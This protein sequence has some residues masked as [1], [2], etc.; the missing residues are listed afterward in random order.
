MIEV[1]PVKSNSVSEALPLLWIEQA[2]DA[3]KKEE[4]KGKPDLS[5][6]SE[7]F[8]IAPCSLS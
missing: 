3:C 5:I 1:E 6:E 2:S 8:G 7:R 4:G